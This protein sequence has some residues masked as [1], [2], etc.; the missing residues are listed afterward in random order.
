MKLAVIAPT[1][2]LGWV[3]ASELGYHMALGQELFRDAAYY[4]FYQTLASY[5]HFIIVDN[6]AAE[7][8][9]ERAEFKHIADIA[10]EMKA[11]EIILPDKLRDFEWTMENSC[12][13]YVL[14]TIPMNK[15]FVVPQGENWFEWQNSLRDLVLILQ[16]AT[17]GLAKWLEELPGGRRYAM[18]LIME[19]GYHKRFN[20]HMLGVHSKPIAEAKA[21][22]KVFPGV[23]GIDT[24]APIAYAQ[25][26]ETISNEKHFSLDWHRTA[27]AGFVR[28]N[29]RVYAEL[30]AYMGGG[31][32]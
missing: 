21:V 23:R 11:D 19:N 22:A 17:I 18:E 4:K 3:Q 31:E 7:P 30:L 10:L 14:N 2:Y 1:N 26:S 16:P 27:P 9:E 12:S 6:G 24:G 15:R 32:Q 5:G 8:E 29:I 28:S 25:N 20:V 13:D